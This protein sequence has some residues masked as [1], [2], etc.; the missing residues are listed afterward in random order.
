MRS[1]TA[2]RKN[3][4]S[5]ITVLAE[6]EDAARAEIERQLKKNPSRRWYLDKW[7][8]DG[9]LIEERID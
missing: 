8:E 4:L 2:V 3:G 5:I 9:Q 6:N 1:F 7:N